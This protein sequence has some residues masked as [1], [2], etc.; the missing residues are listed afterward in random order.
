MELPEH[1]VALELPPEPD[2]ELLPRYATPDQLSQIHRRYWG[3]I[4]PVTVRR[5]PLSWFKRN[6]RIVTATAPFV[7]EAARR[8]EGKPPPSISEVMRQHFAGEQPPLPGSQHRPEHR[9]PQPED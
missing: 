8:F 6:G 5:W 4:S 1:W 3:D 2:L 7:A 9:A